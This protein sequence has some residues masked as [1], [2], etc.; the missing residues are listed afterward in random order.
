MSDQPAPMAPAPGADG[1]WQIR[2]G[3][4]EQDLAL[5][6]QFLS[7]QSTWAR[8]IPL[9]TVRCSVQH[10]L[11]FGGFLAGRQV[12]YARVVTDRS[13]FAYLVDVFVLPAHRGQGLSLRLM[14]AV[15]AHPDLQGLRRFLLA[16]STAAGLYARYGFEPLARPQAMMER[17]VPDAYGASSPGTPAA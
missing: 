7:E 13:T 10:S 5:I 9:D 14:D 17:W 2:T 15:M 3:A 12:A 11:N 4:D 16:T 6:H 8:G 1:T